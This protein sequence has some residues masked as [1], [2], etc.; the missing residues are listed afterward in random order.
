MHLFVYKILTIVTDVEFQVTFARHFSARDQPAQQEK[1][2]C[3]NLLA[4]FEPY[5]SSLLQNPQNTSACKASM[6]ARQNLTRGILSFTL[7]AEKWI[8]F[9]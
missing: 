3:Y 9:E 4:S 2:L 5:L 1:M 8:S 7:L 6:K